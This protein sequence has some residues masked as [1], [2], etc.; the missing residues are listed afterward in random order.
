VYNITTIPLRFSIVQETS[1]SASYLF[2]V[3]TIDDGNILFNCLEKAIS[4]AV[5]TTSSLQDEKA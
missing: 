2:K 4:D 3:K 1:A 5:D